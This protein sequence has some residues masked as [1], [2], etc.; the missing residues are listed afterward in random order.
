MAQGYLYP[1]LD[2][3][4]DGNN[5]ETDDNE[6][7]DREIVDPSFGAEGTDEVVTRGVPFNTIVPDNI[8][9]AAMRDME[10]VRSHNCAFMIEPFKFDPTY[11]EGAPVPL[12]NN[13]Q[14]GKRGEIDHVHMPCSR[15]NLTRKKELVWHII[16][17]ALMNLKQMCDTHTATIEELKETIRNCTRQEHEFSTLEKLINDIYSNEQR[18][19]F[20]STILPNMCNLA[21]NVDKICPQP[22]PLLRVGSNASV[23]LSQ[24]Q[25]A[26]LLACG[27]FCLFPNRSYGDGKYKFKRFPN[28][29]F[30]RLY[31]SGHPKKVEKLKCILH[32]F[33]R[34][35]EKKPNGVITIQRSAL[36]LNRIPVWER[37]TTNLCDLH[38]TTGLRIEDMQSTLQVD[39]ANAYIGGGVLR[40]GCVQEEIRFAICP[41]MLVSLL[42]CEKMEK[43][44]CVYL[45]G[46]ERY[47]LYKGYS[48]TFEFAGDYRDETPK[49]N[50]GRRSCYL[51]AMDAI[52]FS[53]KGKQYDMGCAE[54]ELLKAY[55]SFRQEGYELLR[56]DAITTGN[57]GCGA[58]N[59]DRELK[60]IIQWMAA[61]EARCSL[62]YA[63]YRDTRLIDSLGVVYDYLRDQQ[64]NVG[65]LYKYLRE[66]FTQTKCGTLFDSRHFIMADD[67]TRERRRERRTRPRNDAT[68]ADTSSH[69]PN[70]EALQTASFDHIVNMCPN[71]PEMK[72]MEHM[73]NAKCIFM[74]LPFKYDSSRSNDKPKPK[75]D[76]R[77]YRD[78]W[79]AQHVRMPCSPK[80]SI[81]KYGSIWNGIC[82]QLHYLQRLCKE[83][84][85]SF[86]DLKITIEKCA[87]RQ[88]NMDCLDIL[89]NREYQHVER[90]EFLSL[91]LPNICNLALTVDKV[92]GEPP[93]LLRIGADSSLTM[94]QRQAASLLACSF[95][96]LFPYRSDNVN[97]Q[98][99]EYKYFQNPNFNRLY[100]KG[101][102]HKIEKLK[103][104]LNYFRRITN[105]MP[106]GVISF[107]RCILPKM[108]CPNWSASQAKLS[109]MH[110]TMDKKIEDIEGVLHV[111]FANEYIGGGV[112][113]S[114][115]V[116]EEILFSI[117]PEM[118]VSLLVCE[119]MTDDEC[120]FLIGCERFSQYKGYGD[121]FQFAEDYTDNTPRDNWGRKW[122]HVVAMDA[123]YFDKPEVQYAMQYIDRE[124]IKAFTSFRTR[125]TSNKPDIVFGI[126]TGNW[127][128]GVFNGD[129]QLKGKASF[130]LEWDFCLKH[131]LLPAIIQLM[132]ASQ[133][134]RPLIYA[135]FHDTNL[136]E[137]FSEVYNYLVHQRATVA[138]LYRY[139]ECYSQRN[140]QE[141]LFE[142]IL[143]KPIESLN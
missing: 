141:N 4:L 21:L 81:E 111:D 10:Q 16:H 43:N 37:Q 113:R 32:Y 136:A 49:D 39:F 139:L 27:F 5:D 45:I 108:S 9:P 69:F 7:M 127:G 78:I 14:C 102:Q 54:R 77:G 50:W 83:G 96:C 66:Y 67:A 120:I 103:C 22:P 15:Y 92:F 82:E 47:S 100:N 63:A 107:R 20:M 104:I 98:I 19:Y 125:K 3:I 117:C 11:P 132:A 46:C 59:G 52:Y 55:V 75:R 40:G 12:R 33:Q 53:D 112:L 30:D 24:Q 70:A 26:A 1:R 13:F 143:R 116:Q 6:N 48:N 131:I 134:Q 60:A 42:L 130:H 41:E 86:R 90:Q 88:Y 124:L 133:A 89:I 91:V 109:Q 35:T 73:T 87:G 121:S 138:D 110:L 34:I 28:P 29:N 123:L 62:I 114:G 44:E 79:D 17:K 84:T 99:D 23:T 80:N 105:Q 135:T 38:L 57:W 122:S 58:F 140:K 128:C 95:F 8:R 137:S 31:R 126:A 2:N 25:A 64:A 71:P 51:V 56:H 68:N 118:L 106:N 65:Y 61:S 76:A 72:D 74:I 85:A 93:P 94:S 142:F 115:C 119:K 18:A 129:R 101:A 36:P 97:E